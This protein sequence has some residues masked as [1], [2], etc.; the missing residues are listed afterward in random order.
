MLLGVGAFWAC[1]IKPQLSTDNRKAR[2]AAR[3]CRI[4]LSFSR[5]DMPPLDLVAETN[6]RDF[7]PPLLARL[8]A[9][10]LRH[11]SGCHR[12]CGGHLGLIGPLRR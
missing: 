3:N 2:A 4:Y 10:R 6:Q 7:D 11:P 8:S 1:A 5:W 9:G 12:P